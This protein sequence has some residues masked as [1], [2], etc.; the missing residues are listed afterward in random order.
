[1]DVVNRS[2]AACEKNFSTPARA[3][4]LRE[5]SRIRFA[6]LVTV[7][8]LIIAACVFQEKPRSRALPAQIRRQDFQLA[9]IK[10][11]SDRTKINPH[12]DLTV[13]CQEIIEQDCHS[14][15]AK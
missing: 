11:A 7:H 4:L 15:L 10:P 1:M 6:A 12:Y 2:P 14:G 13:Y 5:L 3:S 9:L 8:E